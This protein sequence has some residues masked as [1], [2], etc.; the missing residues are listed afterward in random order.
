VAT[1]ASSGGRA[2]AHSSD[3]AVPSSSASD[4][5]LAAEPCPAERSCPLTLPNVHSGLEAQLQAVAGDSAGPAA[6]G[7]AAHLDARV[8]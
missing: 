7:G 8:Y 1:R 5:T 2:N 4:P 6:T 3:D